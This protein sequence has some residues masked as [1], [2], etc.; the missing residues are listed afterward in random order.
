MGKI[1]KSKITRKANLEVREDCT[2][3]ITMD[4]IIFNKS[5]LNSKTIIIKIYAL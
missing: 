2:K 1:Q 5:H 4:F 3:G